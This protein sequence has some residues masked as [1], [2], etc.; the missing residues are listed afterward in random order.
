MSHLPVL[1]QDEA[2]RLPATQC[3]SGNRLGDGYD[4]AAV[5]KRPCANLRCRGN[6]MGTAMETPMQMHIFMAVAALTLLVAWQ[7]NDAMA[8]N[9]QARSYRQCWQLAYNRGWERN[10][11]GERQ[12]IRNCM[13]GKPA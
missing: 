3:A 12:F 7:P 1:L 11:R 9:Q 8:Q 2:E 4:M 10:T 13:R 6:A 5:W